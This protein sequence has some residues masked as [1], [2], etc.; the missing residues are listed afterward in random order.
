MHRYKRL[1]GFLRGNFSD[2]TCII[3]EGYFLYLNTFSLPVDLAIY[4]A[5]LVPFTLRVR[6]MAEYIPYSILPT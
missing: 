5:T 6:K 2:L 1:D 4:F 3:H